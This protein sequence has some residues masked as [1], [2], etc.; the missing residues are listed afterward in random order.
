[1]KTTRIKRGNEKRDCTTEARTQPCKLFLA[2]LTKTR[3]KEHR[4]IRP[5]VPYLRKSEKTELLVR[6]KSL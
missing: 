6:A 3:N 1:M 5:L 2:L 4:K